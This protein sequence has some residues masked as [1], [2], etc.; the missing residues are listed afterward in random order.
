MTDP[1]LAAM[2]ARYLDDPYY[3]EDIGPIAEH[4]ALLLAAEEARFWAEPYDPNNRPD[5]KS[6]L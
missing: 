5:F 6:T 3:F 4:E 1:R 2:E